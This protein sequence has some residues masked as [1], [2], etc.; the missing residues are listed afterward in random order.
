MYIFKQPRIGGE[1]G[2]H[3]DGTFLY[4]DPQSVLGFW[5]A[6][7]DCS[8]L[9]GCL[10]AIPGSHLST[11]VSRKFRRKGSS[12]G[13]T[14]FYPSESVPYDLTGAVPIECPKGTLVLLHSG[15][16]HYSEQN[17]SEVARHAYSIHVVDGAE[18]VLYPADNWL[19][20]PKNMPFRFLC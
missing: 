8:I 18:D 2:A 20:R 16:V 5:W 12:T 17:K 9:N 10:W 14:E 11:P 3:Q 4:T 15:L 1:V 13:G 7:D 19:Q 6:L